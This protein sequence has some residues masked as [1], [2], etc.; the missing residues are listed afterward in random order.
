MSYALDEKFASHLLS[1]RDMEWSEYHDVGE[2]SVVRN[3][4]FDLVHIGQSEQ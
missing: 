2:G 4:N 1:D 3:L